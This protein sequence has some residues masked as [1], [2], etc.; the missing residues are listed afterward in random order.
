MNITNMFSNRSGRTV[1]YGYCV[2][3]L[4]DVCSDNPFFYSVQVVKKF[5]CLIQ[6]ESMYEIEYLFVVIIGNER[7]VCSFKNKNLI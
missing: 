2:S 5:W 7:G 3:L 6:R 1:S 4:I